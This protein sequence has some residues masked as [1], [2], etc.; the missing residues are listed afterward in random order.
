MGAPNMGLGKIKYED[1]PVDPA[2]VKIAEDVFPKL[3]Q[4][5]VAPEYRLLIVKEFR[6]RDG[7]PP[8][9]NRTRKETRFDRAVYELDDAIDRDGKGTIVGCALDM[10]DDRDGATE[11]FIED[12]VEIDRRVG[13]KVE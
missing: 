1:K 6:K 11:Q 2:I 12:L 5:E 3:W 10:Y 7:L 13:E 4:G 8:K 9:P